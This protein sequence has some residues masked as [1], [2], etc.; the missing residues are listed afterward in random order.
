[1]TLQRYITAIQY[2]ELYLN[3]KIIVKCLSSVS[4]VGNTS[5][6]L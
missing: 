5:A 6:N 3:D 2:F 4:H 1:M